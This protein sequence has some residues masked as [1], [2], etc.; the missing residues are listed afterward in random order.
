MSDNYGREAVAYLPTFRIN[1]LQK[2]PVIRVIEDASG[3]TVYTYRAKTN[4]IRAKVFNLGEYTVWIGEPGT[5]KMKKI[6]GVRSMAED[7]ESVI[8][9]DF[10]L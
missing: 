1:G 10:G 7:I 9:I 4:A 5:G 6:V 3:E 2:P 8:T